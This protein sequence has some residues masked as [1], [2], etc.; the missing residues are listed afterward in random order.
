[1][2]GW[3]RGDATSVVAILSGAFLGAWML[4]SVAHTPETMA[5][6]GGESAPV[7]PGAEREAEGVAFHASSLGVDW[8]LAGDYGGRLTMTSS[9]TLRAFVP[10]ALL[11]S[12]EPAEDAGPHGTHL[13]GL[14][15]AL[16][17]SAADG[18]TIVRS[19]PLYPVGRDMAEGEDL[20]LSEVTLTLPDASDPELL[21][22]GRWLV[23]VH[24]LR[25]SGKDGWH[26][27]WTYADTDLE[28]IPRLLG[29]F[30]DGC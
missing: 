9:G 5:P 18:W 12:M 28:T 4:P 3:R 21:G 20:W 23:V 27:A 22:E 17:E 13:V 6:V 2:D 11:R 10:V 8:T 19:G 1:M 16:A 7:G 30:E 25:V 29:W 26:T 15:L 24:E 14:R